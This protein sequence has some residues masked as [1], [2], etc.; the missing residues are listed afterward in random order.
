GDVGGGGGGRRKIRRGPGGVGRPRDHPDVLE[1]ARRLLVKAR[2][3][4]VEMIL[5]TDFVVG[6][7]E[8]D[9]HGPLPGQTLPS[10]EDDENEPGQ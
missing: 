10:D 8:V 7:I 5:P 4:G 2:K 1:A 9:E 6:D 3:R